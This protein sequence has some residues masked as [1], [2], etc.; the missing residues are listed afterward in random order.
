MPGTTKNISRMNFSVGRGP[1]TFGDVVYEPGGMFGPRVQRDF[2]MV[3]LHSGS[4]DLRVNRKPITLAAGTAVLLSPGGQEV[5]RFSRERE[6]RHSWCAIRPH[7]VPQAQQ[8]LFRESRGPLP[9]TGA[10]VSLL[11]L[12]LGSPRDGEGLE[13]L[14]TRYLLDLG[15]AMFCD[16]ALAAQAGAPRTKSGDEAVGKVSQFI[17]RE[18]A[19][20]LTLTDLARAGGVSSQHLLKLFRERK[21]ASPTKMLYTRRLD[22]ARDWLSHTGLSIGEIADRCGFANAFHFSRKFRQAHGMSPREWRTKN[23]GG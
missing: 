4:L 14:E 9:F 17:S 10:M 18:L 6:S 1:V 2:Q 19:R 16:F 3:I 11:D 20:P 12:A 21:M 8:N 5:F 22:A 13:S 15:L 7:A 23:W